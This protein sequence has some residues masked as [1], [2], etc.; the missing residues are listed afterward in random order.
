MKDE[1]LNIDLI[2]IENI[3]ITN[4]QFNNDTELTFLDN[5]KYVFDLS[6]SFN[7]AINNE[8][9]KI[10]LTFSCS[11]KTFEKETKNEVL[12]NANFDIAFFFSIENLAVLLGSGPE[13]ESNSELII[14]I[15]NIAYST[16]RGIIFTRCQG[17]I[18]KDILLPIMPAD[19][20][21]NMF[22]TKEQKKSP[23]KKSAKK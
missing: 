17:T 10:R 16:S 20:I 6:H 5:N 21:I 9:K 3:V 11:I 4:A 7:L 18:L 22:Q 14:T 23:S 19:K 12:I 13:F 8:Q 15:S 2:K 1:N